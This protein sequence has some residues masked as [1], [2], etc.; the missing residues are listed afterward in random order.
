M[1][2]IIKLAVLSL[3]AIL[4]LSS[5]SL[6]NEAKQ[7]AQ[8]VEQ[9]TGDF[10][11]LVETPTIEN[12]EKIVHP[13]SKLTPENVV[14]KIESNEKLKSLDLSQEISV[15]NIGDLN[16]SYHDKTLGGNVYSVTVQILV[17]DTPIDVDL[18]LLST[19]GGFG[20]YDFDIK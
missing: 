12:A 3:I 17:G 6:I 13:S 8:K 2:K 7:E 10:A 14:E 4:A 16:V 5:C 18:T 1:K 9:F 20:L 11:V 15:G 19:E